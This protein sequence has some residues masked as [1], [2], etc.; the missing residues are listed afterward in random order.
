M[1]L[2]LILAALLAPQTDVRYLS[3]TG[4]D[5]TVRWGF[6]CTD[7]RG[8]LRADSIDVPSCWE[9][10]GFGG[11]DYGR[12]YMTPGAQPHKEE[13]IYTTTFR[14]APAD[15]GK[16]VHLVF[17]G[18][19]T[20]AHVCINGR[21][22]GPVHQGA[23]YRFRYDVTDKLH[24][25]GTPNE[26]TVRVSKHSANASVNAAERR[27][28][29]WIFGGIYRP[30]RLE[31]LPPT[32][33]DALTADCRADGTSHLTLCTSPLTAGHRLSAELRP[34]T[35]KGR[36]ERFTACLDSGTTHCLS[37][38]WPGVRPWNPE[39]PQLYELTLT[40]SSPSGKPLHRTTE[41]VG[42]RTIEFRR[43]DGL[44]L[45]GTKLVLKGVNRHSFHPDG[46]RTT[47]RRIS[48]DD[49]LLIKAMN[50]NAVRSHYPPDDH[51]LAAADSLGLLVIDE[52]AGWHGA[53]DD[54]TAVRLATEMLG[55]DLNHPSVVLWSNGNEGGWNTVIDSLFY[56][57]DPQGRHVVHPWANFDG[58][59][60]HHYPAFLTGPGRFTYGYDLFMP[61]EFMHGMYDQ[62]HGAGLEDFWASYTAHPLFAGG[63]LWDFSDN[64]VR[65][66]DLCGPHTGSDFSR[67]ADGT[68]LDSDGS[69]APDGILGPY[70]E[71]EG[72][73][74]AVRE[75]WA[76]IRFGRVILTP[77]FDGWLEVRNTYLFT[78]L[79]DC[80]M[81]WRLLR[82]APA[83]TAATL[84]QSGRV[85]LPSLPPQTSGRIRIPLPSDYR[86]A[87][88]LELTARHPDGSEMCSWAWPVSLAK[89]YFARWDEHPTG[90]QATI[91]VDDSTVTLRGGKTAVAFNR[92][93]GMIR[94]VTVDERVVPLRGG[95]LSVGVASRFQSMH[96]R[97]EGPEAV[98][99]ARYLGAT[100]SIVWRMQGDGRLAMDAVLLNRTSGGRGFD[101]A[102]TLDSIPWLGYTF[103]YDES[104]CR[105]VRW[106][107][108]GPYRVWKN[109]L[110]GQ[111]WGI[112][113]KAWNNTV[114][115]EPL[116]ERP[117]VY[118]EFKG[119]HGELYWLTLLDD[120]GEAMQVQSR[121]DGLYVRLFTPEEPQGKLSPEPTMPP[122]PAGDL[123]FLIEIP[124]IRDFKPIT[125]QGPQSQLGMARIKKG[126]E[127]LHLA[128]TFNFENFR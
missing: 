112:W 50:M 66:S 69:N 92:S 18:V 28:D 90:P 81:T 103:S 72:S 63:F 89:P 58:L 82:A 17:D 11:Y 49:A 37:H 35:G 91:A 57:L 98:L 20:D 123:S 5:Q 125:Q 86:S 75:I 110:A 4:L 3:G 30:V 23:F 67:P 95:P 99:T 59:D 56:R 34:L 40:L 21:A 44:Y 10:Q 108:R 71:K 31:L 121:T 73:Y 76:P 13:G 9:L 126:D 122:F 93:D 25:D 61:T 127:G 111:R 109:R 27:A 42:F 14:L 2:L 29:W 12:W 26:L 8:S 119:Y 15:S 118:P 105:G 41:R 84:L 115:G 47:S 107:G 19:M 51:F 60:T 45:N 46:G 113:T 70:R 48:I 88:I 39:Q 96:W 83:D 33:I 85:D 38:T 94:S 24:Y 80:S 32:H 22:A 101:D 65:R 116:P 100:D 97:Q 53:Y 102:L 77:S 55:R 54:T 124:A 117:L 87:D 114:T 78:N 16:V 74:Y 43:Q 52:L 68:V 104:T 64:A 62:G 6:Y 1:N 7:G 79:A 106:M 128:L 36:T 120:G